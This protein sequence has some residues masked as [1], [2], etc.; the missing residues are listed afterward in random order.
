MPGKCILEYYHRTVDERKITYV[1]C[2]DSHCK[3]VFKNVVKN[4]EN[5]CVQQNPQCILL[6]RVRFDP[7]AGR[8]VFL[9]DSHECKCVLGGSGGNCSY[10]V[11][12]D[13]ED[14]SRITGAGCEGSCSEYF[15]DNAC[16]DRIEGLECAMVCDHTSAE[17]IRCVCIMAPSDE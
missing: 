17:Q 2:I 4:G 10:S 11:T 14:E 15:W 1:R 5:K 6:E 13:P 9:S 7:E 12:M 3:T 8:F 16:T